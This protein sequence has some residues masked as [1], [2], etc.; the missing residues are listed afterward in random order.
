MIEILWVIIPWDGR[1]VLGNQSRHISGITKD[2]R[3]MEL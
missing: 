3:G 2:F 1:V